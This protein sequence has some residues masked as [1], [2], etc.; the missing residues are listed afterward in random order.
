MVEQLSTEPTKLFLPFQILAQNR[1]AP[2]TEEM[3]KA[4]VFC[5]AELE[6]QKG[7]G[8]I[9]KQTIEKT[10]FIAEACY[11]FWLVPLDKL[12]LLFDGLNPTSHTITYKIIAD[13]KAFTENAETHSKTPETYEAFLSDNITYF[14]PTN[15]QQTTFNGIIT[16]PNFLEEFASYVLNAKQA[17]EL[18][19]M[20]VLPTTLDEGAIGYVK[21]ELE[22]LKAS[23]SEDVN[24][25]YTSMKFINKTT[26][27]Y[28]KTFRTK[29]KT[30]Q[31]EYR[32]KIKAQETI[33]TPKIK[34]IQEE[35]DRQI[36][37]L[38][39]NFE[40]QMLP[41][42]EEKVK[43]EKTEEQ[44]KSKIERYK[45]E[46]KAASTNKDAVSKQKW[47]EKIREAK[48]EL[49]DLKTEMK[50][51][52]TRIK[53]TDEKKA[54]EIFRLKSESEAKMSA[55]KKDL[56]ELEASREA[57][58][59]VHKQEM[60]K[61]RELTEKMIEQVGATT[62]LREAEI[63]MIERLALQQRYGNITVAYV[64]FYLICYQ[65]EQKKRY[66]LILPSI[67]SNVG[68]SIKLKGVL[69]KAKIKQVFAPRFYT[70]ATH[71]NRLPLQ[72]EQNA[73][74]ER[75]IYEA[76]EKV[77][78]LKTMAKQIRVGLDQLEKEEWFSEKE[79]ASFTQA[80]L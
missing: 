26:N 75:E 36:A 61:L 2:F 9:L 77:D 47:K 78:I 69:G 57:K 52:E 51:A 68:L 18:T 32:E 43:L 53:S 22:N 27:N 76:G 29:I 4:A 62:K 11:P 56:L 72:I 34:L 54:L 71:L 16:D 44:I 3:E 50:D 15:E 59:Q 37:E 66:L 20:L 8:I 49:S 19:K 30:I 74:L 31:E 48:K 46:E 25:L 64:P 67:V 1:R 35:Y 80:L 6:R 33:T 42:Q 28:L 5:H 7:G 55:A 60:G 79:Y 70:I 45:I 14:Q 10:V 39:Q 65:L 41:L 58:I 23:F 63:A 40:K 12:T 73:V 24:R 21:Q 38:S 13:S 17:D